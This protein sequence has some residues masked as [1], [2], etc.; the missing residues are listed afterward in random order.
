[1]ARR[2][3]TSAGQNVAPAM[4]PAG[5]P[6]WVTSELVE[7]TI[8]TWQRYYDVPLTPEDALAIIMTAGRLFEVLSRGTES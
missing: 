4:L 1:M 6:A 5:A 2:L 8:S 3:D 7:L